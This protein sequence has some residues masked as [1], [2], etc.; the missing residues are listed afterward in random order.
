MMLCSDEIFWGKIV[1]GNLPPRHPTTLSVQKNEI[2]LNH[3]FGSPTSLV[4]SLPP[5]HLPR[6][7]YQHLS[8]YTYYTDK[9]PYILYHIQM[10]GFLLAF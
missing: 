10:T 7:S 6:A 3:L 2:F 5:I 1:S 8:H 4:D 9:E